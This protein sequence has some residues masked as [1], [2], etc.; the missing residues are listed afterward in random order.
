MK[1]EVVLSARMEALARMV[2]RGGRVCDVGCDHG[3]VSIYLV[4][5]GISPHVLA[6]DVRQGPLS[7]AQEHIRQQGLEAYIE[8]RLSDGVTAL[9]TG[10]ADTVICAGMGGRLM[11]RILEEG[12][13]KLAAMRE[14]ILQPQSEIAAFRAYLRRAG[15]VTVAEDMVYEDG[16]YYPMM[17]VAPGK[18]QTVEEMA[19][20]PGKAGGEDAG[21]PR[22]HRKGRKPSG[23]KNPGASEEADRQALEDRFGKMLLTSRHPVLRQYLL[24]AQENNRQILERLRQ[25]A[26]DSG[27]TV[28]RMRELEEEQRLIHLALE[29]FGSQY[30]RPRERGGRK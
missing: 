14:L 22:E 13:E 26:A 19:D 24:A 11:R 28:G 25:G 18:R 27:R 9:E 7:R 16:K 5:Q 3:W 20:E 30:T 4:Q 10:E 23:Q 17:K 8:T 1:G 2:S 6:M 29:R 21:E 15:Y 12:R